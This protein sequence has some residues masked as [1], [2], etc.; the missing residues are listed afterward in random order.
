MSIL[1]Q[2]ARIHGFRGLINFEM[3]LEPTTVITGTNNAG[4]TSFLKALQIVFGNG[5]FLSKED[6]SIINETIN[7]KIVIDV[8]IIPVDENFIQVEN[9]S[10]EWETLFTEEK[11]TIEAAGNQSINLR[12]CVTFDNLKN[13]IKTKQYIQDEWV[14]YQ[15]AAGLNWYDTNNGVEKAFFYENIPFFYINAD[16][17]IIED[18]KLKS[19]YLGKLLSNIEYAPADILSIEAQIKAL[20]EQA[21]NSSDVLSRIEA[22]LKELD[23]AMD[24]VNNGVNISPFPKKVR[25][26][27]KGISIQYS[28]FSMEYHGMGTRSWSSLLTLKSFVT[29]FSQSLEALE[30]PFYPIV[31]IEEPE[32]HLHPNAQKKLYAQ[33]ASIPGQKIISTHSTYI[34]ASSNLNEIR[35]LYKNSDGIKCGKIDTALLD[36]EDIRKINRQVINTRGELFFSKVVVFF[37]GETE[38]QALPIFAQKYFGKSFSDLGIDFV[39][40]GGCGNYLTFIRFAESF[41]IP[42]LIFSDAEESPKESVIQ[43]INDSV[44]KDIS[45]VIFVDDG[46]NFE[47]QLVVDGFQDEIKIA[48]G[49]IVLPE[50]SHPNH[51]AAKQAEI[52]G[53]DDAKLYTIMTASKTQFA[54]VLAQSIVESAKTLPIK[55]IQ[56]FEEINKII[57]PPQND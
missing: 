43:Q 39:G 51:I 50:G 22:S 38:E 54:P 4:K 1:L 36:A 44:K 17:D 41:N 53:Y 37:E 40:V 48:I 15:D 35:N 19:S 32:A 10:E 52:Q 56:L 57:N 13:A 8:L 3:D 23:T 20:N 45:K 30:E 9:F 14:D 24:N 34:A 28:D 31:A 47:S 18:I 29:Q 11:I 25:D 6:F 49:K 7:E 12:T 5:S 55:I 2:M 27:N 16:R 33:I 46:N 26:L 42:Y 21:V